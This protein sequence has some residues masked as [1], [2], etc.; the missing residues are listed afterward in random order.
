MFLLSQSIDRGYLRS[1]VVTRF[2]AIPLQ[3]SG[4][5]PSHRRLLTS[6]CYVGPPYSATI[7]SI[8]D[9][10][11]RTLGL[12]DARLVTS[13]PSSSS[14]L[15]GTPGGRFLLVYSAIPVSPAPNPKGSARS[16]N[17]SFSGLWVRFRAYTLHLAK[18]ATLLSRSLA[19]GRLSTPYPGG[20]QL[21]LSLSTTNHCQVR[22]EFWIPLRS[23]C[24]LSSFQ[25]QKPLQRE[26]LLL[27]SHIFSCLSVS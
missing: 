15:S 16:Q 4:T 2:F 13:S 17:S 12:S 18:L 14:M 8:R 9:A 6:S 7:L 24:L 19:T 23:P 1:A 21:P 27:S 26:C 10:S 3:L 5:H 22:T 25:T 11:P 20:P